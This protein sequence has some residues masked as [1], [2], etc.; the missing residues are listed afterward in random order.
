[1]SLQSAKT[2]QAINKSNSESLNVSLQVLYCSTTPLLTG[3]MNNT[4]KTLSILSWGTGYLV[5]LSLQDRSAINYQT[6]YSAV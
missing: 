3:Q 6:L 1:M 2:H 5:M 4:V